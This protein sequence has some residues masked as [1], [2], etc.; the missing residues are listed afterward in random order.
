[1]RKPSSDNPI[2]P[3]VRYPGWQK[4]GNC[5]GD[6]P[7]K[8]IPPPKQDTKDTRHYNKTIC[9]TCPVKKECL[10]YALANRI[11]I[12]LWGG[13]SPKERESMYSRYK[14]EKEY[15]IDL[16]YILFPGGLPTR[17]I[18]MVHNNPTTI[19]NPI[20]DIVAI[21]RP[22]Y[23]SWVTK[24]Y[25]QQSLFEQYPDVILSPKNRKRR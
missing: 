21:N 9:E 1:M 7:N 12:G 16:D 5:N 20:C 25:V 15:D 23:L 22:I 11:K 8:Y 6:D 19:N 17:P 14:G 2:Y 10:D 24:I 4:K 18:S 3:T 13:T